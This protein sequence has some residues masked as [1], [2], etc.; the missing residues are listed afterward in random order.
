MVELYPLQT[1]PQYANNPATNLPVGTEIVFSLI[2]LTLTLRK[3]YRN[4]RQ[5]DG[6]LVGLTRRIEGML[7]DH[8]KERVSH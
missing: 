8:P 6:F 1:Y 2:F 7:L 5:D 3:V 4:T